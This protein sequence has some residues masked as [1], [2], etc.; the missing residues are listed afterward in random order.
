[1]QALK[2]RTVLGLSLLTMGAILST[3]M[4]VVG[5]NDA[6]LARSPHRQVTVDEFAKTTGWLSVYACMRHELAV[7]V[8]KN[9]TVYRLGQKPPIDADETDRI[10]TPLAAPD[11]C[12][13]DRPAKR[14]YGLVE[15]DGSLGKTLSHVYREAVP[16]P[17][18]PAM[19]SGVVGFATGH[20]AQA[21]QARRYLQSQQVPVGESPLLV[22]GREPGPLW[23]AIFTA[24]AG[25]HG[26]LFC[27]LA[28]RWLIR[29]Y[30]RR[31]SLLSGETTLEEE[32][33]FNSETL[34]DEDD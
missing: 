14:Y 25:V 1:M 19:V 11:D 3:A 7:A 29:G 18:I 30:R 17:A 4:L 22:K 24:V 27:G 8:S 20:A 2:P 31:K 23:V 12:N 10:F 34:H 32:E 15:N 26:Y 6:R 21:E 33:F 13:D 5:V 9:G 16:P 28:I